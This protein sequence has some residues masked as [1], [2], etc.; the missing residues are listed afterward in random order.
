MMRTSLFA[1]TL[2][3]ASSGAAF[4]A[5]LD[6]YAARTTAVTADDAAVQNSTVQDQYP[7]QPGPHTA[8]YREWGDLE[9]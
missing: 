8:V 4:A 9:G 5:S 2:V 1:L 7:T 6:D 3:V